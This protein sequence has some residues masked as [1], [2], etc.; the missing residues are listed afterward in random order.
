MGAEHSTYTIRFE[1]LCSQ[2]P[3]RVYWGGGGEHSTY[4]IRF[5]V[6]HVSMT[7]AT[8]QPLASL[9]PYAHSSHLGF[10]GVGAE[11]STYI[12]RFEALCSQQPFR[13][14]WGGGGE[15][16]TY[17]IRFVVAHFSMTLA[18]LQPLTSLWPYAHSSHVGFIGVGG[19]NILLTSS[20]L[21]PYAH[22]RHLGFIHL[23]S[24][25]A[26]HQPAPP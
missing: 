15:H 16:S 25:L 18:T 12:I 24:T 10:I 4:I 11:H 17:I 3:F 2:Q 21:R 9:G 23:V 26:S 5:V 22:S 8:L 13:V 14:Y 6:A 1:A 20:A 19:R 7:L